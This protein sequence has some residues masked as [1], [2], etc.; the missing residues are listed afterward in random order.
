MNSVWVLQKHIF[1]QKDLETEEG[2]PTFW[3]VVPLL[4]QTYDSFWGCEWDLCFLVYVLIAKKRHPSNEKWI[5]SQVFIKRFQF[6]AI[7]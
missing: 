6:I 5:I 4:L 7:S 1:P 2:V 3:F